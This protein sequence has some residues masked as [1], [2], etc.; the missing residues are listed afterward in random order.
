MLLV[1]HNYYLLALLIIHRFR[2]SICVCKYLYMLSVTF[3]DQAYDPD[4]SVDLSR[5]R[6]NFRDPEILYIF[7][8]TCYTSQ[9]DANSSFPSGVAGRREALHENEGFSIWKPI[10]NQ[11]KKSIHQHLF[12]LVLFHHPQDPLNHVKGLVPFP[13]ITD[14]I[15]T[16]VGCFSLYNTFRIIFFARA[17]LHKLIFLCE[18]FECTL[19][20][21]A[22]L[23]PGWKTGISISLRDIAIFAENI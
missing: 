21:E 10:P 5:S 15:M 2:T 19:I 22:N 14:Q 18:D 16:L 12:A 7:R 3:D 11:R 8:R 1:V 4:F 6:A 20:T 17:N 23:S 9:A 13:L